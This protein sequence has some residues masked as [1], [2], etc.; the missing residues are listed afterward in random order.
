M[1]RFPISHN[2][3][4][5]QHEEFRLGAARLAGAGRARARPCTLERVRGRPLHRRLRADA[6]ARRARQ[7][8]RP[9]L[10]VPPVR[11]RGVL[12]G[13]QHAARQRDALVVH[14]AGERARLR[15]RLP[16]RRVGVV[17]AAPGGGERRG[18]EAVEPARR[19]ADVLPELPLVLL[20]LLQLPRVE[21]GGQGPRVLRRDRRA[22]GHARARVP[23]DAARPLPERVPV[24][25]HVRHDDR[26]RRRGRDARRLQVR[27]RLPRLRLLVGVRALAD[28]LGRR[29]RLGARAGHRRRRDR[30]PVLDPQLDVHLLRLHLRPA[31]PDLDHPVRAPP[32]TTHRAPAPAA[33]SFAAPATAPARRRFPLRGAATSWCRGWWC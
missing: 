27:P 9:R 15:L 16:A 10:P 14:G 33:G 30:R 22:R 20:P 6:V 12:P 17:A 29:G 11:R 28:A 13:E 26:L 31:L 25:R 18:G 24:P 2:S 21:R 4:R 7:A 19:R 3:F 8:G 1:R 5:T 32:P 23:R